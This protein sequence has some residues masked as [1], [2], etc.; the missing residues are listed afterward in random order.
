[1]GNKDDPGVEGKAEKEVSTQEARRVA[2]QLGIAHYETS[3]M[4]NHNIEQV[5]R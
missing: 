2:D 5:R 3:A 1:M 4:T